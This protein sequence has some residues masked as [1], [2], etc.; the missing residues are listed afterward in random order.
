MRSDHAPLAGLAVSSSFASTL[1][2]VKMP[3]L[4]AVTKLPVR[5]CS[6]A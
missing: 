2:V 6:R 5:P 4:L 1:M 3:N